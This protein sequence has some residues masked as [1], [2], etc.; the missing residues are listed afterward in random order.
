MGFWMC[1]DTRGEA[2]VG[3]GTARNRAA[4][5]RFFFTR[6]TLIYI[7]LCT[8]ATNDIPYVWDSVWRHLGWTA[9]FNTG[10]KRVNISTCTFSQI[11]P[12]RLSEALLNF[13]VSAI[14]H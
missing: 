14:G 10:L 7:G 2:R 4:R 3:I 13:A 5:G 11:K 9:N 8:T 6:L 1:G 12:V